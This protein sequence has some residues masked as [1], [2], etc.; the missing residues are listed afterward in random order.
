MLKKCDKCLK[1][2]DI[3]L[4]DK[5]GSTKDG[6]RPNCKPCQN[7]YKKTWRK[8]TLSGK[9]DAHSNRRKFWPGST[10]EQAKA[11]YDKLY[12]QQNGC[13][14]ICSKHQSEL[15]QALA[16][17]HNHETGEVRGLLCRPCK[18]GIGLLRES[19]QI[20]NNAINYLNKPN[21]KLVQ[22]G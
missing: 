14:A 9:K 8:Q 15:K 6:L 5:H 4:F 13:C 10:T 20:L 1:E 3:I 11:N 17:D 2:L 7:E 12:S 16:V 19:K 22:G 21:I 18:T